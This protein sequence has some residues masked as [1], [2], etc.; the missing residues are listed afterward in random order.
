MKNW[1]FRVAKCYIVSNNILIQSEN[2]IKKLTVWYVN[3]IVKLFNVRLFG[4]NCLAGK[5]RKFLNRSD[6]SGLT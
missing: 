6:I 1:F 3:S 5:N 2:D 4:R